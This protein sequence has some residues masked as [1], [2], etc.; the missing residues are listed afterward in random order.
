MHHDCSS[1]PIGTQQATVE[2]MELREG[3]GAEV[4]ALGFS[5]SGEREKLLLVAGYIHGTLVVWDVAQKK[6]IAT[7]SGLMRALKNDCLCAHHIRFIFILCVEWL[8]HRGGKACMFS[9]R[10]L[11]GWLSIFWESNRLCT[12][13]VLPGNFSPITSCCFLPNSVR[14]PSTII[15]ADVSGVVCYHSLTSWVVRTGVNSKRVTSTARGP[16]LL[17]PMTPFA[18]PLRSGGERNVDPG[19]NL[20]REVCNSCRCGA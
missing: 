17:S 4:T 9:N 3:G 11:V 12:I 10:I 8:Y 16:T 5:Y 14:A 7:I 15:S 18:I 1:G 13:H 6:M 2:L 20:I 19:A